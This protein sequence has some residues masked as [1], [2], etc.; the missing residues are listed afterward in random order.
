[1]NTAQPNRNFP[2]SVCALI[3]VGPGDAELT[4]LDDLFD[5]IV[6]C[7]P[8]ITSAVL[9][10]DSLEP[11]HLAE[12]YAALPITI[13]TLQHPRRGQGSGIWGGLTE[14]I[15]TGLRYISQRLNEPY[16]IRLDTDSL[17]LQPFVQ[18]LDAAF[19]ANPKVAIL[20]TVYRHPNG[21]PRSFH[22]W[23]NYVSH[24]TKR[25]G[26][27]RSEETPNFGSKYLQTI[28]GNGR[29]IRRLIEAAFVHGYQPG[30]HAQG[31]GYVIRREAIPVDRVGRIELRESDWRPLFLSED[32]CVSLCVRAAGWQLADCNSVGDPLGVQHWGIPAPPQECVERGYGVVHSLKHHPVPEPDLRQAFRALRHS[33]S[34]TRSMSPATTSGHNS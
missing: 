5:S 3:P 22:P 18:R 8:L 1:M 32:V 6:T 23:N 16:I 14:G 12:R 19:R 28:W 7:E 17:V 26:R 13:H 4:R 21:E 25:V 20:G 15:L 9:I 33:S 10:D 27:C 30:E 2:P 34:G 11:R 31:G 29:R 24:L